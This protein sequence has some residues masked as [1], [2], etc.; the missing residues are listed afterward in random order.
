[1]AVAVKG[2]G[3][4]SGPFIVL[5]VTNPIPPSD[6]ISSQ[7]KVQVASK[8]IAP[9]TQLPSVRQ[10]ARDLN[11]APNTV[12]RAYN[13][14]EEE[15]WITVGRRSATIAASPPEM[16]REEQKHLLA[17]TLEHVLVLA[18][19]LGM[20]VAELHQEIDQHIT[21]TTRPIQHQKAV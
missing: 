8:R 15:G 16:S 18:D 3:R 11:V 19:Q 14:L 5:D 10:L 1:M 9:G 6:Q 21:I 2:G 13:D 7:I 17:R 12:V 4:M 20:T